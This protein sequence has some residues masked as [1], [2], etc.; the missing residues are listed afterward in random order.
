M[1]TAASSGAD[2]IYMPAATGAFLACMRSAALLGLALG[3]PTPGGATLRGWS[4]GSNLQIEVDQCGKLCDGLTSIGTIF[5]DPRV[6]NTP[7]M[8]LYKRNMAKYAPDIQDITGFIPINYY[9][10][11]W[12]LYNLYKQNGL[13]TNFTRARMVDAANHFGPFQTGFGNT[14][15]W[16][17][18]LPRT[19]WNCVYRVVANEQVNPPHWD[20]AGTPDCI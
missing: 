4:G 5:N 17:P 16:R 7:E 13:F 1:N 10:N 6:S 15:T 3:K 2:Y 19:P 11:G 18:A 20:F 8:Q 12:V 9:H 14:I